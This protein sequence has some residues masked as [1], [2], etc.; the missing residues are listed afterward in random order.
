MEFQRPT[1]CYAFGKV[2]RPEPKSFRKT[3]IRGMSFRIYRLAK[4][5]ANRGPRER[6]LV[7]IIITK[8]RWKRRPDAGAAT[9]R[10]PGCSSPNL[11]DSHGRNGRPVG[12]RT[13]ERADQVG[14]L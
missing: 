9:P 14:P 5:Q 4:N 8:K 13:P 10:L 1:S 12:I 7:Q 6:G 11:R 3:V 2:I